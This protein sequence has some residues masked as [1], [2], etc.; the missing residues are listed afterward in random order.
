MWTCHC[1][2]LS[3]LIINGVLSA[4]TILSVLIITVVLSLHTVL[5]VLSVRTQL[6][7]SGSPY[8][9]QYNI[10]PTLIQHGKKQLR[11]GAPG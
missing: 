4:R 1:T 11:I 5:S 2:L 6:S 7:G 8:S 9:A 3:V 10:A